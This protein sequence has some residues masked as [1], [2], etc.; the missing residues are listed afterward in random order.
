MSL[1][2]GA[3]RGARRGMTVARIMFMHVTC[4]LLMSTCGK[5]AS[6]T[7]MLVRHRGSRGA[8]SPSDARHCSATYAST[9]IIMHMT[10]E[11]RNIMTSNM[12]M[13][14]FMTDWCL[15]LWL[16]RRVPGVRAV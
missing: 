5:I 16:P 9:E 11:I 14:N 12:H 3:R 7:G 10:V 13:I 1:P 4:R 8:A 6:R 15:S 2:T